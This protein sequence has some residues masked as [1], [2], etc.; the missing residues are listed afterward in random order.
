M[1]FL[2]FNNVAITALAACVPRN[3]SRNSESNI[4]TD[5]SERQ[6]VI[7]SIGINE[8]RY[9]DPGVTASDMCYAAA[10][11]LLTEMKVDRSEI[12]A[13]VFLSQTSDYITPATAPSLQ[14]RLG[15]SN[16]VAC[17]DIN[18]ACSGYVYGLS[19]CFAYASIPGIRKVLF[20]NGETFSKVVSDKDKVNF[21]LY[22][23]AGT[24]TLIESG[25]ENKTAFFDLY[26]DGSGKDAVMIKGGGA[27]M[28][29]DKDTV[30]LREREDNNFRTEHHIYM[31]GIDV[32]NF[33]LLRVPQAV[34]EMLKKTNLDADSVNY[35]FFH[36]ANKFM[37]DF[38]AKK[39]K[40]PLEKVP[41]CLDKFGN[42]SSSSIPLTIVSEG[43]SLADLSNVMLVGFG[44]GLSWGTA[45]LDLS[46][47]YIIE[48]FEY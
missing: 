14:A 15:L 3:I 5:E 28:P 38:I 17:F 44:G 7:A 9:V 40:I 6:K 24:A 46:E 29:S 37:T 39:L 16:S 4:F 1:A 20:L 30:M 48:L 47:S 25:Q 13:L 27:R 33:A 35:F 10:E 22:G 36:Q 42:T 31:N 2:T 34:R 8:K 23:D 45:C 19:I 43:T 41:Y 11:R 26:S 18:L 12:D 32:F 21:P